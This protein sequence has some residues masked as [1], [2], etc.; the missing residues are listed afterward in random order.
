MFNV[1]DSF[2]AGFTVQQQDFFMDSQSPSPSPFFP[3]APLMGSPFGAPMAQSPFVFP[4][5]QSFPSTFPMTTQE[6][7]HT[8]SVSHGDHHE[9]SK[10][11]TM[12]LKDRKQRLI[13]RCQK[14]VKVH[15][16]SVLQRFREGTL[17]PKDIQSNLH[18]LISTEQGIVKYFVMFRYPNSNFFKQ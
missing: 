14:Q 4:T 5:P 13:E 16:S 11:S 17:T 6:D 2:C 12:N 7:T 1:E 15:R 3:N 9:N 8:F 18:Q 10:V